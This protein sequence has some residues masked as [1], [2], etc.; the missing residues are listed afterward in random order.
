M[1][2]D[3]MPPCETNSVD[4]KRKAEDRLQK[5]LLDGLNSPEAELR[6]EDWAD[7][8][9]QAIEKMQKSPRLD[10]CRIHKS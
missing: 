5:L 6:P 9:R 8:R 4:E 2:S 10:G 3:Q 1:E 7:I